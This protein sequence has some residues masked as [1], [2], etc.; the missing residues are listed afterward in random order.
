MV[1]NHGIK[2]QDFFSLNTVLLLKFGKDKGLRE[3]KSIWE[4]M[5]LK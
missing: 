2:N 3:L 5:D 4:I 1:F